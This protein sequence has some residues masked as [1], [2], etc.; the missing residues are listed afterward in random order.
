MSSSCR[1]EILR[2]FR[3]GKNFRR[4]ES[5]IEDAELGILEDRKD[6]D[7]KQSVCGNISD[8]PVWH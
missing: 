5:V 3:K 6:I 8:V 2:C 4:T 1:I 7:E